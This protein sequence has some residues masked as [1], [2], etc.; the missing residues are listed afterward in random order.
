MKCGVFALGYDL[1]LINT[2]EFEGLTNIPEI[3]L[4]K[5]IYPDKVK[6]KHFFKLRRL[7]KDGIIIEEKGKKN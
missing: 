1:T 2:D 3:I 5:R 7:E 4:V 6:G